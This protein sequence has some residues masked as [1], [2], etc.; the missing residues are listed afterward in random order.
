MIFYVFRN[1]LLPGQA[2]LTSEM[3]ELRDRC[4]EQV[5]LF[6]CKM[7]H[8]ATILFTKHVEFFVQLVL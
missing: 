3:R 6:A 1:F 2:E 4:H 8:V 7:G 5:E